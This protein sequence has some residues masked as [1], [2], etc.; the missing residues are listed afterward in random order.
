MAEQKIIAWQVEFENGA[1]ELWP[2]DQINGEPPFGRWVTPLVAGGP[3][4][5]NGED[6]E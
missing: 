1:V 2:A 6:S 3:V 4:I 5:D